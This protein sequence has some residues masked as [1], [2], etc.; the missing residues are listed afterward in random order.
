MWLSEFTPIMAANDVIQVEQEPSTDDRI[1]L[2]EG[3]IQNNRRANQYGSFEEGTSRDDNRDRVIETSELNQILSEDNDQLPEKGNIFQRFTSFVYYNI[4]EVIFLLI[5]LLILAVQVLRG[6]HDFPIREKPASIRTAKVCGYSIDIIASFMVIFMMRRT[7][8]FFKNTRIGVYLPLNWA[9]FNHQLFGYLLL[10]YSIGHTIGQIINHCENAEM[11]KTNKTCVEYLFTV[12]EY[13]GQPG[14]RPFTAVT[15]W[16]LWGIL[17]LMTLTA[18]PV[19]RS[20]FNVDFTIFKR[21]WKCKHPGFYEV[22]FGTH[23]FFIFFY[24]ICILHCRNFW[25]YAVGPLTLYGLEV[26]FRIFATTRRVTYIIRAVLYSQNV[27]KLVIE[28]PK[29]FSFTSGDYVFV[30]IPSISWLE[31]HP[32]TISCAPE[33]TDS[34][35]LH[36]KVAN[37]KTDSWTKKVYEYFESLDNDGR[38]NERFSIFDFPTPTDDDLHRHS[39]LREITGSRLQGLLQTVTGGDRYSRVS[40][41]FDRVSALYMTTGNEVPIERV[42]KSMMILIDGPYSSPTAEIFYTQHAILIAGGIAVTPFASILESILLRFKIHKCPSCTHDFI[43]DE[44]PSNVMFLQKV[45]FL[46]TNPES[47]NFGWLLDLLIKLETAMD[48]I[49]KEGRRRFL[50]IYLYVTKAES[51]QDPKMRKIYRLLD[52]HANLQSLKRRIRCKR[53]DFKSFFKEI[54]DSNDSNLRNVT[55]FFCGDPR[56]AEDVKDAC[57]QYNFAFRQEEFSSPV[58]VGP[59]K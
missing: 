15:G 47:T 10:I 50:D 37:D 58:T 14:V 44:T 29:G 13:V 30:R 38:V 8:T 7:I 5:I 53:P 42:G 54:K 48:K 20:G 11:K 9:T 46:W 40:Q 35:T 24:G 34:I 41:L 16:I 4:E 19:F 32:F 26:I 21:R 43:C 36:I 12:H 55:T 49:E 39:F 6:L 28:K 45:T 57:F 17:L 18:L 56:M 3:D 59:K 27:I 33:V 51:E 52:R 23:L 2:V 31:S 1:P 22:F 25:Y